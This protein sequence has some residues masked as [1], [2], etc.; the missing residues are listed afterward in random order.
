MSNIKLRGEDILGVS[1]PT[2]EKA[3][4]L[5]NKGELSETYG[6]WAQGEA[7]TRIHEGIKNKEDGFY[8][9]KDCRTLKAFFRK[10]DKSIF[11]EQATF[12]IRA[13]SVVTQLH[14]M[15]VKKDDLPK[16]ITYAELLRKQDLADREGVWNEFTKT[17]NVEVLKLEASPKKTKSK[18][19]N[20]L[21]I[22][23]NKAAKTL[24]EGLEIIEKL[25]NKGVKPAER[26]KAVRLTVNLRQLEPII[27]RLVT[28]SKLEENE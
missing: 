1:L 25:I 14:D 15:G 12:T 13:Y 20:D 19:S 7:Y 6:F 17:D 18:S 27:N 28:N 2:I 16:K 9:E 10:I 24:L 21:L 4:D 5:A 8:D 22:E 23:M 11:Y 26:N 3:I